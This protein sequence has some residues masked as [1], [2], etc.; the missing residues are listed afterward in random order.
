VYSK[1]KK[2]VE[3]TDMYALKIGVLWAALKEEHLSLWMLC[4]YFF[5]EYVRPQNLYPALD[6][7]PWAQLFLLA[8]IVAAFFDRSVRW[9][10]NIENKFFI[11]FVAVAVLS[12]IF[13]FMP[14][15]S[16]KFWDVLGG[17]IIVY[18]LVIN[19]VNTEKR[20]LLFLLAYSLFNFN[21]A[22]HGTVTWVMRG[23][24]FA[25]FGLIG[26]PGYFRNSGEYA[27]QMLIFG[28]LAISIVVSLKSYWGR[29][30][31]WIFY[32]CAA[33]GYMAVMGASSRGSQIALAAIGMWFLLKQEGGFKGL[34]FLLV[35]VIV[36]YYILP[37]KQMVRFQEMGEDEE[38]VQRLTYWTHGLKEVIPNNPVLG[39]GYLNWLPYLNFTVPEGMGPMQRNQDP[40]NIFIQA[41]AEL[42]LVGFFVFL[43]LILFAFINN[44]QTRALARK[45][46][47]KLYFNLSYGLDAGLIGY[48]VAGNFVSVLYYPFFWVQISMIVMLNNV[49]K[50]MCDS[51][52]NFRRKKGGRQ[53]RKE[54]FNADNHKLK[55]E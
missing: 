22:Q 28:S 18:F 11:L 16:L 35:V 38:S 3:L 49:T 19:I 36:L 7:I 41:A 23:F 50:S 33:T 46:D 55:K 42:G 45:F 17:W 43:F 21:M 2:A 29:Y 4:F 54:N 6:I 9:T 48:L 53:I 32:L 47:N 31:K 5:F 37:D 1:K 12:G 30:K 52:Q 25:G 51:G 27:I 14:E 10:S 8:T 15:R 39:V 20:L 26:S 24:S 40:H 34:M 13:A 44:S